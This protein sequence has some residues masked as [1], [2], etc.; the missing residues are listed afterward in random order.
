MKRD[1]NTG[2]MKEPQDEESVALSIEADAEE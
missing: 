2:E 1:V